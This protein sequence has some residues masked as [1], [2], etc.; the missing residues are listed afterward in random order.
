MVPPT[1]DW[2]FP[3]PLTETSPT[4]QPSVDSP[5]LRVS[6]PMT[7]DCVKSTMKASPVSSWWREMRFRE[8][9]GKGREEEL[10]NLQVQT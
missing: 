5:P 6:S 8:K 10:P 7:F 9:G 2:V 3:H 4:G 1:M